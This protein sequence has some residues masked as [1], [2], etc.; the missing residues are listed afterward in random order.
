MYV[1]A[2]VQK[3]I[4]RQREVFA[5]RG[6]KTLAV[7]TQGLACIDP[8]N[9]QIVQMW[10]GLVASVPQIKLN[11]QTT[12]IKFGQVHFQGLAEGLWLPR[13]VEV[14][15]KFSYANFRNTHSYS[16]F[17][18]FTVQTQQGHESPASP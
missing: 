1:L 4:A 18:L 11:S 15:T 2:F 5:V 10:T 3:P 6:E 16:D 17:R 9:D 14:E 12:R 7:L 13:E 8:A